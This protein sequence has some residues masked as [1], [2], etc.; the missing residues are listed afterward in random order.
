MFAKSW[1]RR[2]NGFTDSGAKRMRRRNPAD[3]LHGGIQKMI[4]I[5]TPS[6]G[7][8]DWL[9]LAVASVADQQGVDVEHI[10]QDGG[11]PKIGEML[12]SEFRNL[13][14]DKQGL[15][16][17]VEKDAGMY[18]AINRGLRRAS[19]E[20]CCYLNC[21][22][23]YL[24]G[25]LAR[26]ANFFAAHPEVDVL[27][28]DVVLVTAQGQPLSYR[29]TVLPR[30]RHFRL[31]HL[32]TATCATFFRRKLLDRGFY[33]DP[34]WKAI[35]DGVWMENLL[36]AGMRMATLHE[37]LAIFSFT[38][39]NLGATALSQS[40][41]LKWKGSRLAGKRFKKIGVV[42]WHRL[43]KALAGAYRLR[44]VEIDVFT[45]ESPEKRQRFVRKNV[46]F[47]WPSQ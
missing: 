24:P 37:P 13:I 46:G 20:I 40:E 3:A 11:T 4:S 38:G 5:I 42:I 34:R 19:G 35:G 6:Y 17:F 36:K 22:E 47:D 45:L 28:G 21:D 29:R 14:E 43:R 27:F 23:Q 30:Q 26:V 1:H 39:K 12:N 25:A 7:Q 18:D 2:K 44:R 10:I 32:N 15:K 9:R 16:L 8:L 31:A 33:F 41:S